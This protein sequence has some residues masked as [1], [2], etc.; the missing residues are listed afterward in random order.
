M[1]KRIGTFLI[2]W[3]VSFFVIGAITS[4]PK[5][6]KGQDARA[7]GVALMSTFIALGVALQ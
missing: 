3:V 6:K 4:E 7:K 1:S 2:V 5:D